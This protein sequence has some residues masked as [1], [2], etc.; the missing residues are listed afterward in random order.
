M[1][2]GQNEIYRIC[3]RKLERVLSKQDCDLRI[4]VGHSNM[5]SSLTPELIMEDEYDY[6]EFGDSKADNNNCNSGAD[7]DV[8]A[9]PEHVQALLPMLY[10]VSVTEKELS[11]EESEDSCEEQQYFIEKPRVATHPALQCRPRDPGPFFE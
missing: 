3:A 10:E 7:R 5:L 1:A 8:L 6:D 4:L 11:S 9:C 2:A